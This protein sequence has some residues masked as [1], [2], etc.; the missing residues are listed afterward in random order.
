MKNYLYL[1]RV[2]FATSFYL[3]YRRSYFG[4]LWS[5]AN[6]I[7]M[8]TSVAFVFSSILR[9]EFSDY[10]LYVYAGM[11]PWLFISHSIFSSCNVF[12]SNEA[13]IRKVR[14]NLAILPV[15]NLLVVLFDSLLTSILYLT[16]L[17][18]T[19]SILGISLWQLFIGYIVLTFFCFGCALIFS[20]TTVYFRDLQW[21]IQ[22]LMQTLFFLTPVLYK[23][24]LLSDSAQFVVKLN[25]LTPLIE[26]FSG[27]LRGQTLDLHLW[28]ISSLVSVSAFLIGVIIYSLNRRIIIFRL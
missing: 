19:N 25:P 14:I 6:P 8:I 11:I 22:M 7:F 15:A 12:L 28:I 2:F 13:L 16:L 20:V 24:E 27:I 4:Y 3:K 10:I 9:V 23:P 21:L 5:L 18:I 1:V 17:L 26:L